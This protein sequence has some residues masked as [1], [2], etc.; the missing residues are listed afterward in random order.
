MPSQNRAMDSLSKLSISEDKR[1]VVISDFKQGIEEQ[2]LA[3]PVAAMNALIRCIRRSSSITFS[4]LYQELEEAIACLRDVEV[5]MLAGR[6]NISV[7]SGCDLFMK[8]VT[9]SLSRQ[10]PTNFEACKAELLAK[11]ETYASMSQNSRHK[12]AEIGHSFIQEGN[13]VLVHGNSRVVTALI[14]KAAESKQFNVVITDGQPAGDGMEAAEIFIQHK[15]PTTIINDAA[16]GKY[17]EHV[18]L[19]LV[20][21]EGVMEN[22]GIVN[23]LGTFQ[24]AIVAKA[25][26]R[27]FYVAVESYK[28]ARIYPL[29]QRDITDMCGGKLSDDRLVRS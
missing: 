15:I 18:N 6:T 3:L 17:M 29:T 1:N 24:V 10:D 7:L 20:G 4:G 26:N 28:F 11:G 12:I 19:C 14:I 21:A 9:R 8:Y 23:K 13:T 27:P 2:K 25:L 22:G 5:D 16:V